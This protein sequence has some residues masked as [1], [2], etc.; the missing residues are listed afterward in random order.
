MSWLKFL[1]LILRLALVVADIVRMF[2]WGAWVER[3]VKDEDA[4]N[5]VA[6]HGTYS[7]S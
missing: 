3:L 1:G 7:A 5:V 4:S 2:A 6:L